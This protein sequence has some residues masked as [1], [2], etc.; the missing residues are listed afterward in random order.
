MNLESMLHHTPTKKNEIA[1]PKVKCAIMTNSTKCKTTVGCRR[2]HSKLRRH[3]GRA[4]QAPQLSSSTARV[5]K[6]VQSIT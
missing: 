2:K 4:V 3:S 1:N 6:T 5:K